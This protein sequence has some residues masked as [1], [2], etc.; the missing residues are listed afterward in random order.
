[1]Q[2][3]AFVRAVNIGTRTAR[4]A[5]LVS[6]VEGLGYTGVWTYANSGNVVFEARA[7]RTELERRLERAFGEALGF[8]A[9]TF[10]RTATELRR[11]VAAEPFV[12]ADDD[13]HF[14]T[15]LK[16]RPTADQRLALQE[17]SNDFD[18]L[19]VIGRDVHWLMH[20]RSTASTLRAGDWDRIVGRHRTTSRNVNLL[21]RL[22]S[23]L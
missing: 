14:I 20:G 19:V 2:N 23:K 13:T 15:F 11:S 5:R 10:V 9:T 4:S 18:T 22:V 6:A 8:E 17:L 12:V 1:M 16:D 3:V 7:R 21:R